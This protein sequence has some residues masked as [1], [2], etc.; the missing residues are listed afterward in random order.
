[1]VPPY[2]ADALK[3]HLATPKTFIVEHRITFIPIM[4]FNFPQGSAMLYA[5]GMLLFKDTVGILMN[6]FM[7]ILAAVAIYSFSRRR[8]GKNIAL[9][10]SAIFLSLPLISHYALSGCPDLGMILYT[11][12]AFFSFFEWIENNDNKYLILSGVFCG[13][14]ISWKYIGIYSLVGIFVLL[15]IVLVSNR[16]GVIPLLL[17][18]APLVIIGS[19]W[20]LRNL[21][22][23]GNPV[24]PMFYPILGG[25][26]W[27]MAVYQAGVR[28]MENLYSQLGKGLKGLILGPWVI[29]WRMTD[30]FA[31]AGIGPLFLGLLP[32]WFLIRKQR[33]H[34]FILLFAFIFYL[35]WFPFSQY[36]RFLMPALALLCIP[37]AHIVCTL[38]QRGRIV[39]YATATTLTIWLICST[40]VAAQQT[41][42]F[43]PAIVGFESKDEFLSKTTWFYEDIRWMNENLPKDAVVLSDHTMLYYLDRNYVWGGIDHQ[44]AIDY[45]KLPDADALAAR[46]SELGV[47]HVFSVGEDR[48]QIGMD[49][50]TDVKHYK[51]LRGQFQEQYCKSIYTNSQGYI[52]SSIILGQS[53]RIPVD[54]YEIRWKR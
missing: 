46:L 16:R 30:F 18:L 39:K 35:M 36:G 12:L 51:M 19:P 29:N 34:T 41:A 6:A 53:R 22:V 23:S 37:I 21:I 4:F 5:L 33:L 24:W 17:F 43:L 9:M 38:C 15:T 27:N 40:G 32:L 14:V 26:G 48:W 52:I 28:E 49:E 25:K 31:R 47:T 10:S 44:G 8:L 2:S 7:G 54:V 50:P 45:S 42:H 13:F 3:Y 20:Y 11:L 1:M